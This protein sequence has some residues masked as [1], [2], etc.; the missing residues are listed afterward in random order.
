MNRIFIFL[1]PAILLAGPKLEISSTEW[2]FGMLKE[3]EI[4]EHVFVIENTGDDTL[5]ISKVRATCGCTATLLS[6]SLIPPSGKAELKSK[7]RTKGM[8][9]K[10]HKHIFV[11][12]NDPENPRISLS[13]T[14]YVQREPAPRIRP[15]PNIVRIPKIPP[16]EE[17]TFFVIIQNIG[18]LPL[19]IYEIETSPHLDLDFV[20][21]DSIPPKGHIKLLLK[22]TPTDYGPIEE[23][24]TIKSN[25]PKVP[26]AY[27]FVREAE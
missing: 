18:E 17:Y 7:L 23:L 25:D 15:W 13:L 5:I 1:T 3:G 26:I 12:S 9:G 10:F 11:Y 14:G 8:S 2:N 24:I 20:P 16:G 27:I 22:Y 21:Q 6:D 19:Y 4:A